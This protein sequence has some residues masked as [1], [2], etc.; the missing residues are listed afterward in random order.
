MANNCL[1]TKLKGVVQNDNLPILGKVVINLQKVADATAA[2]QWL[3]VRTGPQGGTPVKLVN[4]ELD[5]HPGMTELTLSANGLYSGHLDLSRD[6][7]QL[8]LGNVYNI[9]EVIIGYPPKSTLGGESFGYGSLIFYQVGSSPAPN[10]H[11]EILKNCKNL[12][13]Y[14]ASWTNTLSAD[15]LY[16]LIDNNPNLKVLQGLSA[17]EF[18]LPYNTDRVL[19]DVTPMLGNLADAPTTLCRLYCENYG[20]LTGSVTDFVNKMRAAGRTSGKIIISWPASQYIT[21]NDNGE[22]ITGSVYCTRHSLA[23]TEQGNALVWDASTYYLTSDTSGAETV[24][25]VY[26]INTF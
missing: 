15:E 17:P 26:N 1:V 22:E 3:L 19:K 14:S 10:D 23:N 8:V 5:S 7:A 9:Q 18:R 21:L 11:K 20:G 16:A 13:G 25:N 24:P 4:T 12:I 6:N 2:Q